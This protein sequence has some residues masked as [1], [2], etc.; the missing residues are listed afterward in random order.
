MTE[1]RLSPGQMV[2][3]SKT[4]GE[5][6]VYLFAGITGDLSPNHVN[7]EY[8]K[9]TPYG[10]R[11]AHGALLVGY[12]STA[13]T[14]ILQKYPDS[15]MEATPVSLG[16][17]R[18]RFIKPVFINDTITVNYIVEEYDAGR[19]RSRAHI[20]VF[21]QNNELVAVAEHIMKWV[22]ILRRNTV[23][24]EWNAHMFSSDTNRYPFHPRAAYK[25][26]VADRA[27]DP[28]VEY[29]NRMDKEGIDKAVLVHP[30]PYGDDHRLVLECL[31]REPE[32]F[33]GT[34]LFY[35]KDRDAPQK[36]ADLV[37]REPKI[38]ATRFHAHRGKEIYLDSFGDEGVRAL[39]EAAGELGLIIELHIGPNYGAQ[40]AKLIETY[41]H[42]PVLIDHMAE[43]HLG[44][45]V[46]YTDILALARFDNVTMKL[47][48]L[49]HFSD[50][51]P[52]YLDTKPFTRLVADAFA[53][54]HLVW[55]SG[56]LSIVDAHL[57]H[58]TET[59]RD[60]IKGGN[61]AQLLIR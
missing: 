28:L 19:D 32:R 60:K 49:G 55:S 52:T 10:K 48:G 3:F 22:P 43:P 12:M 15:G 61:L 8:M 39:W 16:Y 9:S 5:S 47:S 17:D 30:E 53:P 44:N 1:T 57:D 46:E 18:V 14:M 11:I 27:A 7:L 25:P 13:S 45:A 38:V 41:P 35:P 59:E 23:I 31:K 42:Y 4:V 56:S 34:S 26:Q 24:I 29:L 2:S 33:W 54:D 36:L 6:D 20:E 58:L 21:N 40:V 50:D 51:A 37:Q